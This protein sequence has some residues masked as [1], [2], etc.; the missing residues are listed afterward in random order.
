MLLVDQPDLEDLVDQ[1]D[2]VGQQ[3][4]GNYEKDRV[5]KKLKR[6]KNLRNKP[7]NL[8]GPAINNFFISKF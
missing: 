2:L 7:E 5:N 8:V 6:G 1:L 3:D 4:P